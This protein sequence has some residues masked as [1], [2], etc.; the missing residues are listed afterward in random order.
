MQVVGLSKSNYLG[1]ILVRREGMN[2][3]CIHDGIGGMPEPQ[4]RSNQR[5]YVCRLPANR[6]TTLP[7][8]GF[9]VY[10]SSCSY[11]HT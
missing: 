10:R 6:V 4:L 1:Q 9:H 3:T 11:W 7:L 8:H 5:P 2:G